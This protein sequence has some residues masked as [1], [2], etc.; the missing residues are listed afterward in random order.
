MAEVWIRRIYRQMKAG[1]DRELVEKNMGGELDRRFRP[2]VK[3][4]IL[5]SPK[6]RPVA[7]S[8]TEFRGQKANIHVYREILQLCHVIYSGGYLYDEE[9]PELKVIP[10]GELFEVRKTDIRL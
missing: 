2:V 6:S 4:C 9:K 1:D 5:I 3:K 7:G 10:F 8:L